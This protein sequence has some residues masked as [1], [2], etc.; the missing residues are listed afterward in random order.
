[1][2][3]KFKNKKI[4][5]TGCAGFIPSHIAEYFVEQGATVFGVDD[6]SIGSKESMK[7]FISRKNFQFI[8]KDVRDKKLIEAI[9]K[10]SD[11]VYHGA[12][13]G[14]AISVEGPIEELRVNTE[15]TLIILEAIRKYGVKRFVFPSSASVYG[16]QKKMPESETDFTLPL[17]PYGVS[18]LAAEKY[19]LAYHKLFNI[20]VVC[21][22][23]FNIYGPRQRKDSIY[24]GVVSIFIDNVLNGKT[25]RIYGSGRQTRDFTYIGD[26]VKATIDSFT[27]PDILGQAINIAGG[28]EYSVN[29]LAEKIKKI[30]GRKKVGIAK[31]R[32]RI[33]DNIDRRFGDIKLARKLIGYKPSI[34]LEDGLKKT[35]EWNENFY[36]KRLI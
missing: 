10:K 2:P 17:S 5:V 6:L 25:M 26:C 19:C 33:I 18:K 12:V 22:R 21:L 7:S 35:F 36:K 28:Q 27:A 29:I 23:Y 13:R 8:K 3:S 32:K 34:S 14:V 30:S 11:Y 16:N 4:L 24:G 15:S 31:A 9:I 20:P 1:M